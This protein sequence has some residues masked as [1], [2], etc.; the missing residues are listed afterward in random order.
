MAIAKELYSRGADV[1]LIMGPT[2]LAFSANGV[3]L[4][5]VTTA[6]EMYDVCIN[7]F[8][9]THITI[10]AAAVADYTPI[11]KA[12]EKIKK[13]E[14]SLVLQKTFYTYQFFL[15]QTLCQALPYQKLCRDS[16][17]R[18]LHNFLCQAFEYFLLFQLQYP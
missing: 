4:V 18:R 12:D 10:M 14:G 13:N 6:D 1:T 16:V 9:Q 5:N 3:N 15:G 11:N 17:E 7:K 2:Q 8:E